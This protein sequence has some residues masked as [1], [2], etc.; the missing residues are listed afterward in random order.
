MCTAKVKKKTTKKHLYNLPPSQRVGNWESREAYGKLGSQLVNQ[1]KRAWPQGNLTSW[2]RVRA[3]FGDQKQRHS[4]LQP[5]GWKWSLKD[6]HPNLYYAKCGP[7][8]SACWWNGYNHKS[9][10]LGTVT[11]IWYGC[12]T[13]V[14][15]FVFY[16]SINCDKTDIGKL[17][18][19]TQAV[20]EALLC[21]SH[22]LPWGKST[23]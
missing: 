21:I 16:K 6:D 10:Y 9:S 15:D 17:V 4:G 18:L 5:P 7:Q 20:W 3:T 8:V 14:C 23:G 1:D 13:E 22:F 19:P 2:S 12:N 11:A